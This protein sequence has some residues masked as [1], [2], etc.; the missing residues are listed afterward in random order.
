MLPS[1]WLLDHTRIPFLMAYAGISAHSC[2]ER[3]PQFL[4]VHSLN[5]TEHLLRVWH[6]I[7]WPVGD[8]RNRNTVLDFEGLPWS[9]V[10]EL[11]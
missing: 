7:G 9:S 4:L 3:F 6:S 2:L 8:R 1:S 11:E 10:A 5:H